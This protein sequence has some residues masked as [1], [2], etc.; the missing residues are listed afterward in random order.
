[1]VPA[2]LTAAAAHLPVIAVH[3]EEAPYIGVLFVVLTAACVGLASVAVSWDPPAVYA[4]SALTC[5]SAV[6]AYAATR[7]V[8]FP[9]LAGDV[10][11]WL[12]PLGVLS[13]ASESVVVLTAAF[14]LAAAR[15]AMPRVRPL[16][17]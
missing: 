14:A 10:G 6:L 13:V 16:Q 11:Y 9:L 12:E 1:M 2:M 15:R 7:L 17:A 3:L 4:L 5:G 8:S